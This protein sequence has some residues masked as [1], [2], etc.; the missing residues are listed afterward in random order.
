MAELTT[1]TIVAKIYRVRQRLGAGGFGQTYFADNITLKGGEVVVKTVTNPDQGLEEAQVL[2]ALQSPNVVRVLAFDEEKRAIVMERAGGQPLSSL[3]DKIDFVTSIRI[4]HDVAAALS[5]LERSELVHR[6]LKPENIMV[7][8]PDAGGRLRVKLIDF[9]TTLKVGKPLTSDPVGSPSYCPAEQHDKRIPP[10][11]TDDVYALGSI[12]FLL[13]TKRPPFVAPMLSDEEKRALERTFG[14]APY[15]DSA[16]LEAVQLRFMHADAPVPSLF[17]VLPSKGYTEREKFMLEKLDELIAHMMHKERSKRAHAREVESML[18]GLSTSFAEAATSGGV[19][20]E[21]LE[22]AA[23]TL[24]PKKT[25]T[26]SLPQKRDGVKSGELAPTPVLPLSASPRPATTGEFAQ[27]VRGASN[28]RRLA[29]L[30]V[31][32]L[33]VFSSVVYRFWPESETVDGQLVPEPTAAKAPE[34][35]PPPALTPVETPPSRVEAA[36]SPSEAAPVVVALADVPDAGVDALDASGDELNPIRPAKKDPKKS[37]TTFVVVQQPRPQCVPNEAWRRQMNMNLTDL[38]ANA[39][40]MP[41]VEV[42][43]AVAEIYQQMQTVDTSEE[44]QQVNER[45]EALLKRAMK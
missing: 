18:D 5:D 42:A 41:A 2:V 13:L 1:G 6:D 17:S 39:N 33:L 14:L 31:L 12:L 9:G 25:S 3:L 43:N 40:A 29:V 11:P 8:L 16:T 38:E 23:A 22:A 30:A 28:N 32:L 20:I 24:Y 45:F 36:S 15:S 19:R 7:Q 26:L 27:Q 21:D 37:N 10:H 34:P 44:C 35:A 4:A